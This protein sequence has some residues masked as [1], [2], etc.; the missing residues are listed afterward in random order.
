M[1]QFEG[2][3]DFTSALLAQQ[4]NIIE[5]RKTSISEHFK[6]DRQRQRKANNIKFFEI[7]VLPT[8][9][10]IAF[11][12]VILSFFILIQGSIGEEQKYLY[13]ILD[14]KDYEPIVEYVK[15]EGVAQEDSS[16]E[17]KG[18]VQPPFLSTKST[19]HRVV[20]FYAPW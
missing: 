18:F 11:S 20:E 3:K 5:E 13:E 9:A 2:D 10:I 17:D 19:K 16:S 12:L 7:A 4:S 6:R 8:M 15:P 1:N 14:K